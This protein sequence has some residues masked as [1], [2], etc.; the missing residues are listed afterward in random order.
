[1]AALGGCAGLVFAVW[2][3]RLLQLRLLQLAGEVGA[4]GLQL[5]L[6]PDFRVFG[7]ALVLTVVVG[8]LCGLSPAVQFSKPDLSASF[9]GEGSALSRR[10][11][12]SRLSGSLVAVQVAVSM[13]L[14]VS[15]GLLVRGLMRAKG[16]D[17]GF[18]TRHV[19][20]FQANFAA[21]EF[22]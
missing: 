19:F 16:A 1:L 18:E 20:A 5:N 14:L 10:L 12:R 15:T 8:F 21:T 6:S 4:S 2:A 22:D 17:P 9:K 7:Y 3:S 13:F 11:R